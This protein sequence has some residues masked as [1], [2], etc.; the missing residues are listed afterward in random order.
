MRSSLRRHGWRPAP[1]ISGTTGVG[2]VLQWIGG[3][4]RRRGIVVLFSDLFDD[5]EKVLMGLRHFRHKRHEVIV[6]HVMDEAE[7]TFPFRDSALFEGLEDLAKVP[8]GLG[9]RGTPI[10]LGD[11]ATLTIAFSNARPENR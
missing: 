6:F 10:L 4:L 1:R 7:L 3:R 5:P 8:V 11:V 2:S 9:E